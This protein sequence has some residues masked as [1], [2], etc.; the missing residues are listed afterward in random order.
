MFWSF[1]ARYQN[2]LSNSE[3]AW[4]WQQGY[5]SCRPCARALM[6][7]HMIQIKQGSMRP[8]MMNIGRDVG[9]ISD[10]SCEECQLIYLYSSEWNNRYNILIEPFIDPSCAVWRHL[11]LLLFSAHFFWVLIC[12]WSLYLIKF[13]RHLRWKGHIN[14]G[15]KQ[16]EVKQL[17]LYKH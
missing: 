9:T 8:M 4:I 1:L 15:E 12:H 10:F 6:Q 17:V 11:H 13:K 3:I 7:L 5:V 16:K 14:E 2:Q